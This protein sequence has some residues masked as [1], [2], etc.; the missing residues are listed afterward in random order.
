MISEEELA[1]LSYLGAPKIVTDKIP[2]PKSQRILRDVPEYEP[3]ARPGGTS[4]PVYNEGMGATVKD[5]DGNI[6][7]DIAAG[8]R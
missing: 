6:Y 2:G 3:L 1:R 4:P 8:L 7:I 5:S